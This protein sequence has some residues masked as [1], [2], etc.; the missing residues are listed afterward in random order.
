M[1][2]EDKDYKQRLISQLK[3]KL[4]FCIEQQIKKELPSGT[5][6]SPK[7]VNALVE[8]T[9]TQ[10][11]EVGCDLEAFARHAGRA[12]INVD[13]MMLVVRKSPDLKAAL[14]QEIER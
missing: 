3:G 8:L 12:T 5:A 7:F 2:D 6:Y 9:F 1:S 11:V 4:W 13:D 14:E 10:L